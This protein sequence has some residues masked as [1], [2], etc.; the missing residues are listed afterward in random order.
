MKKKFLKILT[1]STLVLTAGGVIAYNDF[2]NGNN[3][4]VQRAEA[5]TIETHFTSE[6]G[7]TEL[8]DGDVKEIDGY[9]KLIATNTCSLDNAS[10]NKLGY[11]CHGGRLIIVF[12]L[13]ANSSLEIY[14][15]ANSTGGRYLSL[16]SFNSTKELKDITSTDYATNEIVSFDKV[17]G[18]S[19]SYGGHTTPAGTISAKSGNTTYNYDKKGGCKVSYSGLSGYYMMNGTGSESYIYGY[20]IT[21]VDAPTKTLTKL[22]IAFE[23]ETTELHNGGEA[24]IKV[25]GT[26]DD[27]SKEESITGATWTVEDSSGKDAS[28]LAKVENNIVKVIANPDINIV[29][30]L[31]ATYEGIASNAL[32]VTIKHFNPTE[33]ITLSLDFGI[34]TP[35]DTSIKNI[36][37]PKDLEIGED[38]L[39]TLTSTTGETFLGWYSNNTLITSKSTFSS[40]TTLT[41]KWNVMKADD[42][43]TI[44]T[45]AVKL[46]IE[47]CTFITESQAGFKRISSIDDIK[48]GARFTLLNQALNYII[49]TDEGTYY[50]GG[51]FNSVVDNQY[52][53][54][55]SSANCITLQLEDAGLENGQQTY[56]IKVFNKV[57]TSN[58]YLAVVGDKRLQN[59][60]TKDKWTVD[61]SVD[62]K[63]TMIDITTSQ[64]S[65][66]ILF[67]TKDQRFNAYTISSGI[68]LP[69]GFVY[70]NEAHKSVVSAD[71]T[72]SAAMMQY[73]VKVSKNYYDNL[74]DNTEFGKIN[75]TL[76]Q[77]EKSVP[78]VVKLTK[79]AELTTKLNTKYESGLYYELSYTIS[80]INNYDV[81]IA[82][83]YEINE[84]KSETRHYTVKELVNYYL[85]N[86]LLDGELKVIVNEY[87]T[88]IG[89]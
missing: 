11:K 73:A 26:Y 45:P 40:A 53:L 69:V 77:G 50:N 54:E 88:N 44:T 17:E 85:T 72:N 24:A 86:N 61:V 62:G 22:N 36:E 68:E 37:V 9:A 59:G 6:N 32:Q 7:F 35:S 39:P 13:P 49:N 75:V 21:T 51:S 31:K 66:Q 19:F 33:N 10:N 76:S 34:V 3:E 4:I 25:N 15:N 18:Y 46:G 2:V 71:F 47:N 87:K 84:Y 28:N 83:N 38:A 78:V 30:T 60:S 42:N 56:Y 43:A 8:V 5:A 20:K 65:N 14:H 29:I 12:K 55:N 48:S 89:A 52:F 67:R 23:N 74:V 57:E 81:D 1:L 64:G 82:I 63:L 41:A 70:T 79:N 58:D 80:G 27:G 16:H